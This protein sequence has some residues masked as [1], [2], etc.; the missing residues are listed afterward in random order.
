MGF[1]VDALSWCSVY[2]CCCRTATTKRR[3]CGTYRDQVLA[4][5]SPPIWLIYVCTRSH[6]GFY[7]ALVRGANRAAP[8][9][10]GGGVSTPALRL[11]LTIVD[12][13]IY[14]RNKPA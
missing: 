2:A 5:P 13:P 6:A 12:V 8:I 1:P 11:S 3:R 10:A 9:G 7:S 14:A 4:P